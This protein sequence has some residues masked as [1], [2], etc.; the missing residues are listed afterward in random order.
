MSYHAY[1]SQYVNIPLH[2]EDW[3]FYPDSN[4]YGVN[5]GP[6]WGRQVPGGPHVC[7]RNLA[8]WVLHWEDLAPRYHAHG[9]AEL[10]VDKFP[11][12][13]QQTGVTNPGYWKASCYS[14]PSNYSM[15]ILKSFSPELTVMHGIMTT[16]QDIPHSLKTLI[17]CWDGG[18]S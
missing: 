4:V 12:P 11:Y 6:T 17:K 3:I 1:I 2:W 8:I 15:I 13:H 9:I 10:R 18:F 7:P 5:M 16:A 14:I